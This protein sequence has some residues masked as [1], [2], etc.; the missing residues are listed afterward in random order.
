VGN[1]TTY[2]QVGRLSP[3]VE[4]L[5]PSFAR[6]FG[7]LAPPIYKE[8]TPNQLN[9]LLANWLAALRLEKLEGLYSPP[10]T[11]AVTTNFFMLPQLF[12]M[13]HL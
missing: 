7:V 3:E 8:T 10:P 12:H 13:E 4:L 9:W 11:T 6:G 1:S 2:P 5:F